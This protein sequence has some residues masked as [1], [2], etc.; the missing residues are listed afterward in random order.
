MK[1]SYSVKNVRE[2]L[3][4][5]LISLREQNITLGPTLGECIIPFIMFDHGGTSFKRVVTLLAYE[6][7]RTLHAEII[8]IGDFKESEEILSHSIMPEINAYMEQGVC[9]NYRMA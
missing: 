4:E 3:I 9:C 8:A 1:F 7:C 5:H 2:I 6:L